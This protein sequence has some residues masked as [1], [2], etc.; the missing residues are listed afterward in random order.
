MCTTFSKFI[1]APALLPLSLVRANAPNVI[2]WKHP[3]KHQMLFLFF[4][5]LASFKAASTVFVPVGPGNC[6]L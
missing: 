1:P 6:I 5:F 3:I 2:P 4:T